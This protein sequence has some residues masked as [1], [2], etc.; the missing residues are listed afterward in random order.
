M[1]MEDFQVKLVHECK[2][3]IVIVNCIVYKKNYCLVYFALYTIYFKVINFKTIENISD[4]I[5]C[6]NNVLLLAMI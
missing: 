6:F 2:Y 5:K 1:E 3:Y 4:L